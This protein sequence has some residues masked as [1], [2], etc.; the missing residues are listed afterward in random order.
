MFERF[1]DR[2]RR[3]LVLAQ[4]EARTLGHNFIGTEH[5]LLGLL[6]EGTGVAAVVLNALGFTLESARQRVSEE[7]PPMDEPVADKPPFT[8][9]AKKCLELSLRE[10]LQLG[11]NYI[12]TEHMLLGIVREGEG[13]AAQVLVSG[14][15]ELPDVRR[16][17]LAQLG[18]SDPRLPNDPHLRARL[19]ATVTGRPPMT[20][21]ATA[22]IPAAVR[23][24]T[25]DA[26]NG[27]WR[28]GTHHLLRALTEQTGTMAAGALAELGVSA[29]KVAAAL[30][31]VDITQTTDAPPKPLVAT[32]PLEFDLGGGVV[33]RVGDREMAERIL[34]GDADPATL[35]GR[36]KELMGFP[37]DQPV[38]QPVEGEEGA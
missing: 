25:Q 31:A 3:S 34:Q 26:G 33:I 16:A 10:A 11:H 24:A 32:P 18:Q 6:A 37:V 17:V 21:A 29:E 38:D 15:Y 23:L 30:A 35:A 27:P 20:Q 36:L 8:P 2:A 1:T 22:V 14:G 12:G 4:E 9:R 5:I 13:V 19:A 7:I 28:V